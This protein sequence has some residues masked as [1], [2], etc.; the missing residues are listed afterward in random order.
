MG[1][2][3]SEGWSAM[4]AKQLL[5]RLIEIERAIGVKEPLA[6]R[7]MVMEAQEYLLEIQKLGSHQMRLFSE[8][9]SALD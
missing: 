9:L 8:T 1:N 7:E 4:H 5:E 3:S 6:V 2:C